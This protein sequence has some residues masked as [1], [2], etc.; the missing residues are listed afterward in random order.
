MG[1]VTGHVATKISQDPKL[2]LGMAVWLFVG[3]LGGRV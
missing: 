1:A 3:T 2:E